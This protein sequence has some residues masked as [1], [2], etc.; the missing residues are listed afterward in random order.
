MGYGDEIMVAGEARR[1]W[2]AGDSRAVAVL[3]RQGRPRWHP[4]WDGNPRLAW[5]EA[6][7]R[8]LAVRTITNGPGCRPYVDYARMARE[9]AAVFPGRRFS[10]KLRDP[11]LPWRYTAWRASPGELFEV[12]RRE[13]GAYV[14]IEPRIKANASPN[15]DWG[16]ARW[17][18]LVQLRRDL[19]WVQLGPPGP[20]HLDTP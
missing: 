18:A 10:T 6:V 19:D 13:P 9:F 17:Q 3:D 2:N 12:P 1:L 15:K 5:P 7:A 14:V 20:G 8:G 16:W 11:R 4:L